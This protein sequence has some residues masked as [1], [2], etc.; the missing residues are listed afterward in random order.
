MRKNFCLCF[1]LCLGF[2]VAVFLFLFCFA[3]IAE[4]KKDLNSLKWQIEELRLDI[5][6]L[7]SE[8]EIGLKKETKNSFIDKILG[9]GQVE[10]EFFLPIER[11]AKEEHEDIIVTVLSKENVPQGYED[12][13]YTDMIRFAINIKNDSE[14][15][16]EGVQ[17]VLE[18]TDTFGNK[19]AKFK[20]DLVESVV[21]AGK[22]FTNIDTALKIN[23]ST[24][25]HLKVY[26]SNY[27][28]LAFH[29][30]IQKVFF[31]K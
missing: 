28:D 14:R 25:D 21:M 9:E 5:K 10:D 23:K 30:K 16:I 11:T 6:K 1:S 7:K 31:V 2:T 20:C 12:T 27:E 18:I 13:I 24:N 29:Y 8:K 15:D 17:G 4:Q 19:I 22:S 3:T 26:N